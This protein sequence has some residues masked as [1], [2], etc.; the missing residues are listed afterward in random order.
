MKRLLALTGLVVLFIF[1]SINVESAPPVCPIYLHISGTV[2]DSAGNGVSGATVILT[3]PPASSGMGFNGQ[4]TNTTLSSGSYI[5]NNLT[6]FPITFPIAKDFYLAATK[7]G[8]ITQNFSFSV[9]VQNP[10]ECLTHKYFTYDFSQSKA[11]QQT[12]KVV[13]KEYN[14]NKVVSVGNVIVSGVSKPLNSNGEAF[15]NVSTST[16][17]AD[18][19]DGTGIYN[20]YTKTNVNVPQ[21]QQTTVNFVVKKHASLRTI[22]TLNPTQTY[23]DQTFTAS[24]AITNGDSATA[25]ASSVQASISFSPSGCGAVSSNTQSLNSFNGGESKTATF[26]VTSKIAVACSVTVAPSGADADPDDINGGAAYASPDTKVEN[27]VA[28]ATLTLTLTSTPSWSVT[29]P[30]QTTVQCTANLPATLTLIR[31][32]TTV[33]NPDTKTLGVA[34]Y[35]YSCSAPPDPSYIT[36]TPVSNVLTVDK[37]NPTNPAQPLLHLALNNVEGDTAIVAGTI[38][39]ATG[40]KNFVEGSLILYRNGTQG[41][42][43]D[44]GTLSVGV[45]NYTLFYAET[46]NYTSGKITRFLTITPPP[47]TKPPQWFNNITNPLSPTQYAPGKN[48]NFNITWKDDVA[49]NTV[50]FYYNYQGSWNSFNVLTR[51]GTAQDAVYYTTL[52]DLPAGTT[53]YY[54]QA[55]DTAGNANVTPQM[56]YVVEK[57]QPQVG[58][59]I[60]HLALNRLENDLSILYGTQSNAT[61]WSTVIQDLTFSL[62]RNG[63]QVASGSP[64]NNIQTL[65]V[66]TYNYVYNTS[67]G[68]NYTA[69]SI[70]R[71]LTVNPD[72]TSFIL[73]LNGNAWLAPATLTYG[74]T[75]NVLAEINVSSLQSQVVLKRDGGTVPNPE[76]IVLGAGTYVYNGSFAGNQNYTASSI[77]QVLTISPISS[78]L[79]LTITPPSPVI[80]GTQSTATCSVNN[81]EQIPR[82]SRNGTQVSNPETTTLPTGEWQY[83]CS[84]S[85]TQNYTAASIS[86][87]YAVT[88]QQAL[89]HLALNGQEN[90]LSLIYGAQSNATGWVQTGDA[91]AVKTLY[92]N[93]I[94]VAS[95][96]PASDIRTLDSGVYNY[97]YVYEGS[98]NYGFASVTRFLT[99]N[100]APANGF[101][102]LALNGTESNQMITYGT[103]SN[104]T[105]WKDFTEGSLILYRNG[106]QVSTGQTPQ[107]TILLGAGGYNY[108]VYF[109]GSTNYLPSS[110]TRF[111]TVNPATLTLNLI[112]LPSWTVTYPTQTTVQCTSSAPATL[113]LIRNSTTVINPDTQIFGAGQ[114]I[115]SCSAAPN[116][117]YTVPSPLSNVL[118]V[119]RANPVINE[120]N[121]AQADIHLALNETEGNRV[122]ILDS[123]S[124][125]T[126]WKEFNEGLLQLFRDG[127][128]IAQGQTPSEITALPVGVYNYT[129]FYPATQNYT[130]GKVTWFLTVVT[131]LDTASPQWFSNVTNPLSPTTY[132]PGNSY[133]FNITWKDNVA[134]QQVS[135]D[136][137]GTVYNYPGQITRVGTAQNAVY[138]ITL[139]DLPAGMYTYSWSAV[140]TSGNSNQTALMSYVINQA[141]PNETI[142]G[143]P[144]LHL[145]LN[146]QENDLTITYGTQSNATGWS[147][148]IQDLTFNLYRNGELLNSG[149]PVSDIE[150]LGAGAYNYLYNTSGGQNYTAGSVAWTLIVNPA[151]L[152]VNLFL[153]GTEGN[154]TFPLNQMITFLVTTNVGGRNPVYLE[155]DLPGFTTQSGSEHLQIQWSTSTAGT[156]NITGYFL[157]D[158]NYTFDSQTWYLTV[159]C[160]S[161][162]INSNVDSIYYENNWTDVETGTSTIRCSTVQDSNI[163]N[164]TVL[165]SMILNSNITNSTI[166]NSTISNSNILNSRI[167]NKVLDNVNLDGVDW[168]PHFPTGGGDVIAVDGPPFN[169]NNSW[170]GNTTVKQQSN[171]TWSYVGYSNVSHSNINHTLVWNSTVNDCNIFESTFNYSLCENSN[172]TNSTVLDSIIINSTIDSSTVINSTVINSTIIRSLIL[173]MTVTDANITDNILYWGCVTYGG[174]TYCDN[175]LN[176]LTLYGPQVIS[177]PPSDGG[178]GGGG[179]GGFIELLL[180]TPNIIVVQQGQSTAITVTIRNTGYVDLI[181]IRNTLDGIPS[182]WFTISPV[183]I[184]KVDTGAAT[185]FSIVI[186]V[187]QN[188][189]VRDNHLTVKVASEFSTGEVPLTLRV[190]ASP[191][192]PPA[193]VTPPSNVTVPSGGITG[194]VIGFISNPLGILVMIIVLISGYI[195]YLYEYEREKFNKIAGYFKP[196]EKPEAPKEESP[197]PEP[198]E[199]TEGSDKTETI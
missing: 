60:L 109:P 90:N 104:A 78:Q 87:I 3:P 17:S 9:S 40:W 26:T 160:M 35:L 68:Q 86:Q 119:N 169:F 44:I 118:T 142:I 74:T 49:I 80:S 130:S 10:S 121:P 83:T 47:D 136:F 72:S 114:Y 112:A 5:L 138:T 139:T 34:Q 27:I 57:T 88:K 37:A 176:I 96:S 122:M 191:A 124:N 131:A 79:T 158:Q 171:I 21:G 42:N 98:A 165:D 30:T 125:A 185:T 14:T 143:A 195:V 194:A 70:T 52:S 146:G 163:V 7:S 113:T 67:G 95:G 186:N 128:L 54:W 115:Y 184:Q 92:R 103:T 133:Q 43:P 81:N 28:P 126:G 172:I 100:R 156:F 66:G 2:Y 13:V 168:D 180:S 197:K 23:V 45:Y 20:N 56:S 4:K 48:Y 117:N 32:S 73:F 76:S 16:V 22:L 71:M 51:T 151:A 97:T 102:H 178:G 111:L 31:N 148:V 189:P 58:T 25:P 196:S 94:Q 33:A 64:A 173:N 15:F 24:A 91:G 46:Q 181:N 75:S 6:I 167:V 188:A 12:V 134:V 19:R 63:I 192:Q 149:S 107:E 132:A 152:N 199:S 69:G 61:G 11:L 39:N 36:P 135:L 190:V 85:A 198:S 164:S 120:T 154:L 101:V 144:I 65:G 137:N 183:F 166:I 150:T 177:Q 145:A 161:H 29:Y 159:K 116:L 123:A 155:S 193:N 82:L 175:N 41:L 50:N 127:S 170:I 108:T 38:S 8:F 59:P 140:D 129:L 84:V 62:Y 187:P 18:Y 141:Q 105:G 147:D 179:A 162:L 106:T 77:Q 89:I 157:G 153:N 55:F 53:F 99:V 174:A 182:N 1:F 93:G 110:V